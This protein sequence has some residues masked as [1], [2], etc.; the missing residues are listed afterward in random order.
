MAQASDNKVSLGC[1]TL[2]LIA[3]IVLILGA[4]GRDREL[5]DEVNRMGRELRNEVNQ[6][7]KA[8]TQL[9]NE[10]ESLRQTIENQQREN[11]PLRPK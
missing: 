5:R 9:K 2:T 11:P 7:K 10:I 4:N 1:G 8:V 3:I 6:M